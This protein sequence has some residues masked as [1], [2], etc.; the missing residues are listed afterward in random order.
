M[1]ETKVIICR[2]IHDSPFGKSKRILIIRTE[3]SL[4][5][6]LDFKKSM[7]FAF[8]NTINKERKCNLKKRYNLQSNKK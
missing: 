2:L 1:E 5:R 7:V 6:L 4:T 3:E 8:L